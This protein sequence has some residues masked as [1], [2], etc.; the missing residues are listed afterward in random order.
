VSGDLMRRVTM[1]RILF[2]LLCAVFWALRIYYW[3]TNTEAPFS[4]M[5]DYVEVADNIVGSF[6]FGLAR[7][8]T[9][10]TPVTPSLIAFSKLISPAHVQSVFQF[11]TQLLAFIGVLALAREIRFLTRQTFLSL[12][13]LG[14]VAI[15]RPSIF[16]SLKISTEPVCEAFLYLSAALTLATLRTERFSVAL[17]AG[18]SCLLLGLNRPNYMPGI[19]LVF[20][21]IIL[22]ARRIGLWGGL[23]REAKGSKTSP[24]GMRQFAVPLGFVCGFL[25]LWSPWVARNYFRYGE[26]MPMSSSG[27]L[28]MVWEEGG[29]PLRA[30]RYQ[31]LKLADGSEFSNF[32]L[33]HVLEQW[34]KQPTP[35][36]RTRFTQML[37][38]AWL[39]ANWRD[40]PSVMLWRLRQILTN[41]S[42]DGLTRLSREELF[43]S[44]ST[45]GHLAY[46]DTGWLNVFL[47]DKT[48]SVCL[49][50]VFGI[51]FLL[52]RF[53]YVGLSFT[54][55]LVIP[56][57][58]AAAVIANSRYVESQIAL[59]LWL[60]FFGVCCFI[61]D[62][63]GKRI[64]P[65]SIAAAKDE[66]I[67][68]P[69]PIRRAL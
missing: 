41:R 35:A 27:Y 56:W 61:G 52:V 65:A 66:T 8:P 43:P 68:E 64:G 49:L 59:D 12:A 15:C 34:Q 11:F 39:A 4:D 69:A 22:R 46:W 57:F 14:I 63:L 67:V 40:I 32:G 21:A 13:L 54:G 48:P 28:G 38:S 31:S 20:G 62:R 24:A 33:N 3:K 16:W 2:V 23:W 58:G 10:L 50:S 60:A 19:A 47:L 7:A 36:E 6:T 51:I 45:P 9:Y 44:S 53:P 29:A 17:V 25:G 1:P 30:G 55:L 42:A 37:S 26:F 5:A 18:M